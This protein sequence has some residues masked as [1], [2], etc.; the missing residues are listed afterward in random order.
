MKVIIL[1]KA[2][3]IEKLIESVP[4]HETKNKRSYYRFHGKR[5]D[6]IVM[7]KDGMVQVLMETPD[8]D[9]IGRKIGYFKKVEVRKESPFSITKLDDSLAKKVW[10]EA[11]KQ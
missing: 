5:G 10:N 11:L 8:G 3:R 6:A 4:P 7:Q 1:K 2:L 9:I